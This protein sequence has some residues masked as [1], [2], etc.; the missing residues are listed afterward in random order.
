MIRF[1]QRSM[2]NREAAPGISRELNAAEIGLLVPAVLAILALAVYPQFL[3]EKIEP[4]A[5]VA[6]SQVT[7]GAH[8]QRKVAE[9][10]QARPNCEA[11]ANG[12]HT[13]SIEVCLKEG[14]GAECCH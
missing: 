10:P 4:A 3:V 2:H 14:G 8:P 9:I 7:A 12:S 1:F 11:K 5:G 13:R 6:V